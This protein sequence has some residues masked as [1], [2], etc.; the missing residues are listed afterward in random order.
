MAQL[1]TYA[2]LALVGGIVIIA[3]MAMLKPDTFRIS[4]SLRINAPSARIFSEINNL[5]LWSHWSPWQAKDPAMQ[6]TFGPVRVGKDA[7]MEWSGNK[8][9]G[10]GRMTIIE[11]QEP[12]R[13]GMQLDF[14]TPMKATNMAE[15][16]L[17]EKDGQ[18]TVTWS[19]TGRSDFIGKVF[20]VLMNLDRVVG[21][22]FESGLENLRKRVEA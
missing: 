9:V 17:A 11:T 12:S 13:V 18:T 20:D 22:D 2:L 7:W 4:R 10:S 19:L 21:R 6:K 8:E 5:D 3:V 1:L 15:F 16:T 14:K